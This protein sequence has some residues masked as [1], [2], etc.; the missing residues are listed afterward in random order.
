MRRTLAICALLAA[1]GVAWADPPA[2]LSVTKTHSGN[3]TQGKTATWSI[4]VTNTGPGSTMGPMIITDTLPPGYTLAFFNSSPGNWDCSG[5]VGS[6]SVT[7]TDSVDKEVAGNF[8]FPTLML[9]VD[10]PLSSPA[11][12]TNT[13]T[14]SDGS[15]SATSQA[16]T[17]AVVQVPANIAATAGTPQSAM[18]GAMFTLPLTA[19][20]TDAG[21]NPISG[22]AVTFAAPQTGASA[23]FSSPPTVMTDASGR[24]VSPA[25]TANNI[26]G[27]YT[28]TA[29]VSGLASQASFSLANTAPMPASI[30]AVS[31]TPQSAQINKPFAAALVAVVKD[32][33][34][35]PVPGVSVTF[36]A[37]LSGASATFSGSATVTTDANGNATSPALTANGTV[38]PYSVIATANGV[39]KSASFSLTNTAGAPTNI[40]VVSGSGQ[41]TPINAAFGNPLVAVV[42]DSGGNPVSGVSVTF[43][44]PPTGASANFGGPAT[45]VTGPNG[46]AT[47]PALTAN[48]TAGTYSVSATASG[49]ATAALFSLTNSPG[50]ATNITVVSGGGQTARINSAFASPLVALVTDSGGNPISGVSVTFAAPASGAGATFGGPATVTTGSNGQATSPALTANG[51]A[52]AYSVTASATGVA[53]AA[54]FSLTN[55]AG[56]PASITVVSGSGQTAAINQPFA[57]QL[58]AVVKDSGGNPVSGISVTFAAPASGASATFAGPA[59]VTTGANGQATSPAL[60]ANGTTGSYSITATAAGVPTPASFSLTNTAGSPASI[61]V[62]SGSGQSAQ[63]NKAFAAPLV[64]IVKDAGG[65]PVS[66]ASV[67]FVAPNSG[68][69]ATFGGPATVATDANGQATSPGLTANGTT[70]GYN[71]TAS[72]AGVASPATFSLTNTAGAPGGITAVSGSGQTAPINKAFAAP[73]VAVVKDAGGNPVSGVSVTFAAPASGASATFAGPATVTTDANGQATSPGLTANGTAGAYTVTATAAGVSTPANFSL[74]NTAGSPASITAVSGGGQT[75]QI[76]QAFTN[77]LIAVVRDSGGNPVPGVSVTFAAPNSG[78]SAS[79]GG[80]ATVTT[81]ANGQAASPALTANGIAGSYSVSATASGVATAATFSLTNTAGAAGGIT[82][83]SGG[84]QTAQINQPFAN[85]LIAIVKDSG[86]NP[87]SGVTVTFAAPATG[88]SAMFNGSPTVVTGANGQALS[89]ALTANGT[90]GTYNV[91]A[92]ATGVAAAAT[93]SLTNTAGA[94]GSITVV[95]GSGQSAQINTAFSSPLVAVV[96]DSGGNPVSGVSVTFAAPSSG[97][98]AAFSGAATVTTG[99]NGQATSPALTANGVVGSYSVT[100]SAPGVS[101]PA[102]FSLTNTGPILSI[103]KTHTGSFTQ[104]QQNATYTVTVSNAANAGPTNGT[105]TVTENAPAGLTLVSMSGAGWNCPPNGTTCTRSDALNGGSSYPP[106]TATV[107]VSATAASPLVNAV[108]VSGGGSASAN[109]TDS[110]TIA[111]HPAVLSISKSHSGN[112]TQGQ[113]NVAYNVTVS[114]GANAGPT[115]GTVTVTESVPAGLTLISMSG[116]GWNCPANGTTCT[117]SDVLNGGASYPAITVTANVAANAP[118][119]A[120]NTVTVTGGGSADASA[121]DATTITPLVITTTSLSNGSTSGAYSQTLQASGGTAPYT[122]AV[123]SG[124][125]PGGLTLSSGG[126]VTGTPNATGNFPFAAK[127][128]DSNGVSAQAN[129][130]ITIITGV[131]IGGCPAASATVSQAYSATLQVSG[132]ATPYTWSIAGGQLPP[133]LNLDAQQGKISGTPSSASGSPFHFTLKVTDNAGGSNTQDCSIGVNAALTITTTA[134]PDGMIGASYVQPQTTATI[135]LGAAGGQPPYSWSISGGG[136]LPVPGLSLNSA[137]Q[138][139]GKPTTAGTFPFTVRLADSGTSVATQ[140]LSIRVTN[141]LVITACP[142]STAVQGQAYSATLTATGGLLPYTWSVSPALPPG[143]QLDPRGGIISGAPSQTGA[144][145]FTLRVADANSATASQT[146]SITVGSPLTITTS[147]LSPAT[148]NAPFAQ[149]LSATGGTPPYSWSLASGALPTGLNL[150]ATG[151]LNGVPAA[152]GTFGFTA[153]VKDNSNQTA[154]AALT[155]AVADALSITTCPAGSGIVGQP[156]SSSATANGGQPPYTWALGSGSVPIGLS[157]N[158]LNGAL[159]GTPTSAGTYPF[160]LVV[161]DRNSTTATQG[162]TITIAPALTITTTSLPDA[163]LSSAYSQTLLATGGRAPYAWS[164]AS[165][166]LPPGL[167]LTPTGVLSG[168][169]LQL[170]KFS[171]TVNV[172][173]ATGASVQQALSITVFSSLIVA[174]CPADVGEVGFAYNSALLAQGGSAPY[175]WS[176]SAPAIPQGLTLDPKAGVLAG[177]PTQAGQTQFTISVT[178]NGA[179]TASRQCSINVQPPIAIS[180]DS[181]PAGSTGASYSGGV[182]ATG[183]VAPYSWSTISGSLPPGL[184]LDP[185]NGNIVGRPVTAGS[186]AFTVQATDAA[187]AQTTKSL[188]LTVTQGLSIPN[189]PTPVGNVGQ[190]YSSALVALGGAQP[191][192]WTVASGLLPTGLTLD[193]GNALISGTPSQP[194]AFTY[195][196]QVNDKASSTAT[197]TCSLQISSAPLAITSAATLPNATVGVKYTQTLSAAGG[198]APYS[199]SIQSSG[200]PDSFALDGSSGVLSGVPTTAGTYTFMVQ[201]TDKDNNVA[202]QSV[203]LTVLAGTAPTITVSGLTDIVDPGQQPSFNLQL[204]GSY[205]AQID[206]TITLTFT[207]DPS[208]GVDDPAIQFATGGRTLKFTVPAN[209]TTPTFSAPVTAFQ[210]GTVAGTIQLTLTLSSN[211]TD[212]TPSNN[213]LRTVRVDRLAPKIVTL[214]ASQTSGGFQIQLVGFSTT[215][216]V[217][218]GTFTFSLNNGQAPITVVVPMS[219]ASK[220]WFQNNS[221]LQFGG[222]FSLTQPFTQQGQLSVSSV[223]VTLTNAQ[224]T[225]DSATAKF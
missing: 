35:N 140:A 125:L 105:V 65:N 40:A 61:T 110:T 139:T 43:A 153:R 30:A 197:R 102:S 143:L 15:N 218:Q 134:L 195:V 116:T 5:S 182:A 194:G 1:C 59:T 100:A 192:A 144:N 97:A 121:N 162:C 60:T 135:T 164:I 131:V 158:T 147:G 13:A 8:Q 103:S 94:P 157:F 81:D 90:A 51:I 21:G 169:P 124:S 159:T 132:G 190:A 215:R 196:L 29:S 4:T 47:S 200:A 120:T 111:A 10:V 165:G 213:V 16:D 177:K 34:G 3:F 85:Q 76:N 70:G 71:V 74:T 24:A 117:R 52:G 68:A 179:H 202:K 201:V 79:F 48:G 63:I 83:V 129:L 62:I 27:S 58:V 142:A 123:A 92:T 198:D 9:T 75:A 207:P 80:A 95:S 170:G 39:A 113:K 209:S 205:P 67:T 225:S 54:T 178:D 183:G 87:V 99:S 163:S 28:V 7:C 174:A 2:H 216:E 73:L 89:P 31:G 108:A 176:V 126:Q 86:G 36:T 104:G 203:T 23:T 109:A 56:A 161:T 145:G 222:Q 44:A 66:G 6:N 220:T 114:N 184:T 136:S 221:S 217:T 208:V 191:Y 152:S 50:A 173:D 167:T 193:S 155:L 57:N 212:I 19:T 101:T 175:S 112:F 189:C 223:S 118:T 32:A 168:T 128:T 96:K 55:T 160:S 25:L 18:V 122:W 84:G 22:V 181:L 148:K 224:G 33:G 49:I 14:A 154:Q 20:V 107:N 91:T 204:S 93:F 185:S 46:Q 199:W 141:A 82:A 38:G 156:Y 210:T 186:F 151:A 188:T 150:A 53:T 42:T 69:S 219:D 106:I 171:F 115:N 146:C 211:G 37:P 26:A 127:V 72:V 138:I 180:T 137:G 17:V 88:A 41:S 45:V 206:G 149:Q 166:A 133:G 12:V 77:P 64:A 187:G 172:A 98:S 214:T 119:Q 130:A 11:M 78:A